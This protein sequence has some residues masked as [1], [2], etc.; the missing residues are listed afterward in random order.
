M[1]SNPFFFFLFLLQSVHRLYPQPFSSCFASMSSFI[2]LPKS[3]SSTCS[4][5]DGVTPLLAPNLFFSPAD[6]AVY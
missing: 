2:F 5:S 4:P 1:Y 3:S 6:L